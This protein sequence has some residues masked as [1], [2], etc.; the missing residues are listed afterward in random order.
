MGN[1]EDGRFGDLIEDKASL[2]PADAILKDD[3]RLQIEGVL[4]QLNEREK[5]VIKMRFGIMDSVLPIPLL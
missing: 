1:E 2:A 5:A 3:L 4:E